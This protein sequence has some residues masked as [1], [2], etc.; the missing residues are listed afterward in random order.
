GA[1]WRAYHVA[2]LDAWRGLADDAVAA[3]IPEDRDAFVAIGRGM[4]EALVAL[5]W[6][7]EGLRRFAAAT[8]ADPVCEAVCRVGEALFALR[9]G[10]APASL[11]A[12]DR[13]P[14]GAEARELRKARA[15][16]A[17]ALQAVGRR[18][19]A[20]ALA[21]AVLAECEAVG[22][23]SSTIAMLST[24]A[25]LARGRGDSAAAEA[26][27]HRSADLLEAEG[28]VGFAAGAWHNLGALARERGDLRA[29]REHLLRALDLR[30]R[31]FDRHGTALTLVTLGAAEMEEGDA[32][33][34]GR[35]REAQ[36]IAEDL[37][38]DVIRALALHF[39]GQ[40]ALLQGRPGEAEGHATAA[41]A[42]QRNLADRRWEVGSRIDW[43]RV[44]VKRGETRLAAV[45]LLAALDRAGAEDPR[46]R[47]VAGTLGEV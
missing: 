14:D 10:D 32:G 36:R 13:V 45:E 39:H 4:R 24:L 35:F 11:R 21:T 6:W 25:G 44:R 40:W 34:V 5:S 3:W 29:A 17:T 37:E 23:R 7:R 41:L 26:L 15:L 31:Y 38:D 28:K 8:A 18:D 42:L 22:D 47:T 9:V 30:R 2:A 16:R 12:L 20:H 46:I 19:E 1:F 33:C 27:L 43:A